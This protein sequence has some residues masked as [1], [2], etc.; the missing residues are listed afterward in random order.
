MTGIALLLAAGTI[1]L[2]P[3]RGFLAVDSCLDGGGSFDYANGVCDF[4]ENH[5]FASPRIPVSVFL[6]GGIALAALGAGLLLFSRRI[7]SEPDMR[8]NKSLERT[9]GR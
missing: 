2:L 1:A 8:S 5:P 9:R 7:S 4:K 3:L 6:G